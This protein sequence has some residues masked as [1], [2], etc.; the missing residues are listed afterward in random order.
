MKKIARFLPIEFYFLLIPSIF[1]FTLSFFYLKSFSL[2]VFGIS[3]FI[4][5]INSP[6]LSEANLIILFFFFI[7]FIVE[8]DLAIVQKIFP[9][10]FKKNT[11]ENHVSTKWKQL[12][13]IFLIIF[14]VFFAV[15]SFMLFTNLLLRTADPIKTAYFSKLFLSWDKLIFKIN[16]GIW[17]INHFSGTFIENILLW[18]YINI[19]NVLSLIFLISFFFNKE[20]FRKLMMSFF[21]C[22]AIALPLW[23]FFPAIS[24][25][26][27]FRFNDLNMASQADYKTFNG[28]TPSINLKENLEFENE[29]HIIDTNPNNIILPIST[30][31]SM[32]AA[33]GVVIAYAGMILWPPL[34][35]ILIP[36]AIVNGVA[37][38]YILEHYAVDIILGFIVALISI[39]ITEA[40]FKFE[41]TYFEDKFSLLSGFDYLP[42]IFKKII[43]KGK[44]IFTYF[45]KKSQK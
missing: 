35:I 15:Y 32:H 16:P 20:S 7:C 44:N 21:I 36:I 26:P 18:V 19:F 9:T 5:S 23:F 14:V 27:M 17:L 33:W 10:L 34:G 13:N 30:F 41:N 31:P 42:L 37:S 39:V 1:L 25:A 28:F 2:D 4:K 29:V 22:W 45:Y 43:E 24:P 3:N 12:F 38:V 11:A 8:L 40:L 6:G